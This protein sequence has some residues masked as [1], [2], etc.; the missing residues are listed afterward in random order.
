MSELSQPTALE[1]L[2]ARRLASRERSYTVPEVAEMWNLSEAKIREIFRDEPDVTSTQLRTLRP[3]KRENVT[4]RI[5]ESV[6]LRVHARLSVAG[7]AGDGG[8]GGNR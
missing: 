1:L 5:P 3:R 8:S 7:N 6:L 4:L 2:R